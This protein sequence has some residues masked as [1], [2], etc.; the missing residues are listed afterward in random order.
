ML[1]KSIIVTAFFLLAG[2][3]SIVFNIKPVYDNF[4]AGLVFMY[5]VTMLGEFGQSLFE[6]DDCDD[7][8]NPSI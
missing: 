3:I 2:S 1:I 5:I 4:L 8:G 6:G 7:N